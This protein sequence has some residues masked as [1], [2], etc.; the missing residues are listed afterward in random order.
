[1]DN[2]SEYY[3]KR[4][5]EYEQIYHRDDPVRQGEQKGIEE[6]IK[7]A[8]LNRTVLEIACGTGYWTVFLSQVTKS[9]TAIDN[10]DEVLTIARSKQYKNSVKFQKADAYQL[11]FGNLSFNGGMA[12]FWFS[13][14]P[15]EKIQAFLDEFHRV[16]KKDAIVF[17]TDNVYNEGIGGKLVQ[18]EE[19]LNTYKIR[20]LEDGNEYEVL[21][22]YY[23]E[24]QIRDL[25][26][27]HDIQDVYYGKCFWFVKYNVLT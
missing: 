6:A 20:I 19:N 4:A 18:K 12:N 27:K 13:H 11:P 5:K 26:R 24:T 22:N 16:L 3:S 9:I 21:K 14:V 15:K 23:S 2:L 17:M 10:S 1:M 7:E 8:F 25:F